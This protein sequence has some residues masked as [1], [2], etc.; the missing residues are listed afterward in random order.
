MLN[1]IN[2]RKERNRTVSK[3]EE[4]H[5]GMASGTA[6][7]CS[8]PEPIKEVR[9]VKRKLVLESEI[10]IYP[11]TIPAYEPLHFPLTELSLQR[12]KRSMPNNEHSKQSGRYFSVASLRNSET[13]AASHQASL[14]KRSRPLKKC[15]TKDSISESKLIKEK[16]PSSALATIG[17][18][19]NVLIPRNNHNYLDSIDLT[20][21]DG[22]VLKQ[23]MNNNNGD[24]SMNG[25][26]FG[27]EEDD[28]DEDL[29]MDSDSETITGDESLFGVEDVDSDSDDY[30]IENDRKLSLKKRNSYVPKARM[31]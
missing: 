13:Q 15:K 14:S 24:L 2:G 22:A 18:S 12:M 25:E 20:A 8:S 10:L 19:N 26:G 11:Q 27:D 4:G 6:S 9:Q 28:E 5:E 7:R 29:D 23:L 17:K 1:N 3:K 30:T 16:L 21:T 31:V